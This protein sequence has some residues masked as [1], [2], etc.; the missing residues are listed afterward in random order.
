M[1]DFNFNEP[2]TEERPP[3][4]KPAKRGLA[5]VPVWL[6]ILAAVMGMGAVGAAGVGGVWLLSRQPGTGGNVFSSRKTYTRD[7]I[8]NMN[9][10][11]ADGIK[12][13]LGKPDLTKNIKGRL[14]ER[15]DHLGTSFRNEYLVYV[16]N[17]VSVDGAGSG[18]V[19]AQVQFVL[20][21]YSPNNID[22]IEFVP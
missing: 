7:E 12:A 8:R 19:D 1:V 18:K 13:K 15:G 11:N 16:Y 17:N 3:V 2:V 21:D 10:K 22:S 5:S 20:W 4:L 6:W 14:I 9:L